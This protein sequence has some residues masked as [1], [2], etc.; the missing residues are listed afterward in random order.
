MTDGERMKRRVATDPQKSRDRLHDESIRTGRG[1][2]A[3]AQALIDNLRFL[4][5]KLP[6]HATRRDWYMAL[7]Y[8]VRDR[9]LDQYMATVNAITSRDTATKVVA[10]LSAEFLVGPHLGNGLINLGMWEAA[11]EAVSRVGQDLSALLEEEEEPGLGNGG[12]GRLAACY[13]DS[14]ATLNIPGDRLRHPVRVRDLRS[15]DSRRLAGRAHRQVA[16]VRQPLGDCARRDRVRREAW[17][18]NRAR[19]R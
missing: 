8:T 12:L 9:M 5:A 15:G 7:A 13:M 19:A 2:D 1:A 3:I 16:S 18:S 4:Q 14:L 6:Q 11:A 17:W 10:Y